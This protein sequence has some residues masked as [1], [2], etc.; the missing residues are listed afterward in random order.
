MA[1]V[2]PGKTLYAQLGVSA[3]ADTATIF[4]AYQ[5]LQKL[6]QDQHVNADTEQRLQALTHAYELL[7]DPLRRQVYDASLAMGM[8]SSLEKTPNNSNTA[9]TV[10]PLVLH[11]ALPESPPNYSRTRMAWRLA[12]LAL[13]VVLPGSCYYMVNQT[14][15]KARQLAMEVQ[16]V[17]REQVQLDS[18]LQNAEDPELV[19]LREQLE[20]L[21]QQEQTL[22]QQAR[23]A[24][25]QILQT[26][27]QA[28]VLLRAKRQLLMQVRQRLLQLGAPLDH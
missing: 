4:S 10:T 2:T 26:Q 23:R 12:I 8:A 17:Q 7:A 22:M 13:V 16:Q 28:L 18:Y 1:T 19:S 21:Q 6:Y 15:Q 11:P 25:G 24:S 20:Q 14:Q 9:S 5:S 3:D 27:K